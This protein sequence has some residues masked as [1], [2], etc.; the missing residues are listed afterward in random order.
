MSYSFFKSKFFVVFFYY[1][2]GCKDTQLA[3]WRNVCCHLS[4]V[5]VRELIF[6][7]GGQ[8]TLLSSSKVYHCLNKIRPF[9]AIS[10]LFL[11]LGCMLSF[12]E[13]SSRTFTS[14]QSSCRHSCDMH[15]VLQEATERFRLRH[16]DLLTRSGCQF[17]CVEQTNPICQTVSSTEPQRNWTSKKLQP[18]YKN[19]ESSHTSVSQVETDVCGHKEPSFHINISCR[20]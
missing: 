16:C 18:L 9:S 2:K 10:V 7:T 14:L 12:D 8:P 17:S 13:V 15:K 19:S 20:I 1:D 6:L 3:Q 5:Q 4:V 11:S